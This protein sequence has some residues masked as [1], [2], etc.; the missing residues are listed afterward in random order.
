MI[1]EFQSAYLNG[2]LLLAMPM[3][4][5]PR[6]HKAVIF[7]CVHDEKGAM[8]I[9]L[10]NEMAGIKFQ[11]LTGQIGLSD[12]DMRDDIA[13]M[14]VISG[15]PVETARGFLLHS[16]DFKQPDTIHI[17]DGY[18]V[19]GTIDGLKEVAKGN[20]PEKMV[21]ALGYAGWGAEQL[22]KEMQQNAWLTVEPTQDIV[23]NTSRDEMWDK[24][25]AQLGF[26]PM[27]LS[28]DAGHA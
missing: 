27:R 1:K 10:N 24:A 17:S 9:V 21:L 13:N 7:L 5:D 11:E 25:I 3:M 19:T 15:G 8:G 4:G 2:K 26:D 23:F 6:F 22:E 16:D 20:G 12:I 28:G 18:A 14:Q